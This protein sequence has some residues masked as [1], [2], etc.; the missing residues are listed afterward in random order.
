M[1]LHIDSMNSGRYSSHAAPQWAAGRCNPEFLTAHNRAKSGFFVCDAL[2]H[3]SM[4]GRAGQLSGWPGSVG[5]GIATPVRLTTS[6]RCNLGGELKKLPT[7]AAIM[8][9]I[10]TLAQPEITLTNGRAVTS[11]LAVAAYFSKRHDNIIQK[12]QALECSPEFIALNFKASNYTDSTGRQLPCY[13]ITR[14][15][16]AFLA[17]GFTGKKAA[18]FKESYINAFNRMEAQLS[19]GTSVTPALPG[20]IELLITIENGVIVD[21]HPVRKGEF[22]ASFETFVELAERRGF[23]IIHR[24]DLTSISL[25]R[26]KRGGG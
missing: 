1:N 4:V 13:E 7:E 16:F 9:T 6:R 2:S 12:I 21:S 23:L 14:D 3:Q 8:A 15:G 19:T 26:K 5:T 24:D 25:G 11:S 18:I 10:P 17:M 20:Q 22:V